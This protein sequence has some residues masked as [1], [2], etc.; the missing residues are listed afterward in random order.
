V[1]RVLLA[2]AS[3]A[4]VQVPA[5]LGAEKPA[6]ATGRVLD[7]HGRPAAGAAV[8]VSITNQEYQSVTI[9]QGTTD[10]AGRFALA[11][12]T[13]AYGDLGL[14]IEAPGFARWGRAGIP[15]ASSAKRSS[16]APHR[17]RLPRS[18]RSSRD[19][20]SAPAAPWRSRPRT[21]CRDGGALP[22]LGGRAELAT[23]ARART[24]TPRT[25][26]DDITPAD[27]ALRLLAFAADPADDDLVEPW[28]KKEWRHHRPAPATLAGASIDEV[29]DRWGEWHFTE[30]R[31]AKPARP[32]VR[33]H[34]IPDA[35][36]RH[37]LVRWRVDYLHWGYSMYLVMRREGDRW[38][39][40]GVSADTLHHHR[41]N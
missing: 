10:S 11:L 12:S 16:S 33:L 5:G 4:T 35:T 21:I 18:L 1:I 27:R 23:I 40:R 32:A 24:S 3:I 37:A 30:Q 15:P 36:G 8:E 22:Y 26:H 19:P 9:G 39:L 38:V 20:P 2:G 31:I 6:T 34:P 13:T 17:S 7:V 29:C 41:R 25:Q 28:M 14:G